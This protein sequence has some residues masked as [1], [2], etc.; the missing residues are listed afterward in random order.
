M[1]KGGIRNNAGQ[2]KVNGYTLKALCVSHPWESNWKL[3]GYKA[4][5]GHK[6]VMVAMERMLITE[7][8]F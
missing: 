5:Q 4:H 1:D 8:N 2:M 7:E 3:L 6:A